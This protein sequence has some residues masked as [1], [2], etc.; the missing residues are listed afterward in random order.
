MNA[1]RPVERKWRREA[2]K[3]AT[4]SRHGENKASADRRGNTNEQGVFA[5][6][7]IFGLLIQE[8]W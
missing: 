1:E 8:R 4:E 3:R 5:T 2:E 6:V 7:I